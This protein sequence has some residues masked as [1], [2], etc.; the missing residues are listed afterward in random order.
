M[1][2]SHALTIYETGDPHGI[3][4]LLIHGGGGGVWAWREALKSLGDFRCLLAELPEH[5]DSRSN[6]PFSIPSAAQGILEA[7]QSR[8][9]GGRVHVFGHSVGGQIV[10]EMLA[11]APETLL[12]A[13]ISGAQLLPMP[14]YGL[15]VYSE[16]VMALV[17]WLGI[18][19]WKHS[20]AWMRW[21]MRQ[22][23]GIPETFFEDFKTNFQG[24]TRDSWA[25]VMSE[26]YRYRLPAGLEK[27]NIP[28][29]LIAGP[30]ET[31]DI[32]PTNRLLRQLL[33]ESRSVLLP[34]NRGWS[35]AQEHNWP[36]N[37]PELCSQV[38]R[39]WIQ[40]RP[41]PEGMRDA[42]E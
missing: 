3:P 18:A 10:V 9:A 8:T 36:M 32:Q 13:I 4:L 33:P 40:G 34:N 42:E 14:G 15:G 22:A 39:A 6:G 19:P 35:T 21:N 24:L 5:G 25:H 20:D 7:V 30:H 26:N 23:A 41:L 11:R 12:S 2:N 17:Y 1:T 16:H 31:A 27:A 37:D 28:V 38:I 29:L